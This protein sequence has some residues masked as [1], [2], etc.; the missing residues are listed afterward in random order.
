MRIFNRPMFRR[1]GSAEGGITSGVRR[2]NYSNGLDVDKI[3]STK[4]EILNMYGTPPRTGYN[5]YDFLTDWGLRMVGNPPSGN[6]LQTSA[7]EAQEPFKAFTKGKGDAA[8]SEYLA[9][10]KATDAAVGIEK[11]LKIAE[12]DALNK[13]NLKKYP[14]D[15]QVLE[16]NTSILRDATPGSW[17]QQ[18]STGLAIGKAHYINE[19]AKGNYDF[20]VIENFTKIKKGDKEVYAFDETVLDA[21]NVYFHPIDKKFYVFQD[22]NE[23]GVPDAG[24]QPVQV[25][26]IEE[27]RAL[28]KEKIRNKGK[29]SSTSLGYQGDE[30]YEEIESKTILE[31][32]SKVQPKD[33]GEYI[34]SETERIKNTTN[35]Y[36]LQSWLF[37]KW[38]SPKKIEEENLLAKKALEIAL[39]ADK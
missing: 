10:V 30:D 15:R 19:T 20:N 2:Q 26:S 21:N 11:A 3:R 9:G 13:E 35:E 14:F 16:L 25:G 23:D 22:S 37:P 24:K 38:K 34:V 36:P 39:D 6:V 7:K 28:I 1:G 18:N 4:E 31:K 17:Q 12:I 27:G 29:L 32:P 8:M 5:V 33:H